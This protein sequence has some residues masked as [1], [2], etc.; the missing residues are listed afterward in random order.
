[1][2]TVNLASVGLWRVRRKKKEKVLLV[3]VFLVCVW[4]VLGTVS[5]GVGGDG[6]V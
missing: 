3:V 5:V 6:T 1:M 2:T 4:S